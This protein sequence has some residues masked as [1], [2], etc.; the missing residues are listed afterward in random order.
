MNISMRKRTT[1]AISTPRGNVVLAYDERDGWLVIGDNPGCDS[2]STDDVKNEIAKVEGE[3]GV[4][5]VRVK[6]LER[7]LL[8]VMSRAKPQDPACTVPG[9]DCSK[10]TKGRQKACR[11]KAEK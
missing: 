10:C 1:Y 6:F 8:A 4:R 3:I 5:M 7:F 2:L 11:A 9:K